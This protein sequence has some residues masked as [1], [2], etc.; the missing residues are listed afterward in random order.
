MDRTSLP[1]TIGRYS[2]GRRIGEG[3]FGDVYLGT[4]TEL[5]RRVA[6][7]SVRIEP[8]APDSLL[9]RFRREA[10][11]LAGIDHPFICKVYELIALD[12]DLLLVMEYI[13]GETLASMLRE[14]PLPIDQALRI[15]AEL[16]EALGCAHDAGIIHRDITPANVIV[17]HNGHVKLVDFGLAKK[18]R[19]VSAE[20]TTELTDQATLMGTLQ[21]M[22]PEQ[23]TGAPVGA[24]ADVFSFGVVL[25]QCLSGRLPY[26]GRDRADYFA[27]LLSDRR[28]SLPD[29]VPEAVQRLVDGC[30]RADPSGRIESFHE[31]RRWLGAERRALGRNRSARDDRDVRWYRSVAML[32]AAAVVVSVG[33]ATWF[34]TRPNPPPSQP[35][36]SQTALI[37]SPF[38]DRDPRLSPDGSTVAFVSDRDGADRLWLGSVDGGAARPVSDPSLSL[39]TPV[40]A[41]G[42]QQVAYLANDGERVGVFRVTLWGEPVG[43]PVWLPDPDHNTSTLFSSARLIRWL[44]DGFI[45][46]L[47][48]RSIWR[49]DPDNGGLSGA[50]AEL[51]GHD[52][53]SAD[54]DPGGAY[55]V[56]SSYDGPQ[57]D[58]WYADI[59]HGDVARL[60]DSPWSESA[61]VFAGD[62]STVLFLSNE[63]GQ[64]DV[65][66]MDVRSRSRRP[67]TT[68]PQR[69]VNAH[70]SADATAFVSGVLNDRA[71]LW[72]AHPDD[73]RT[74]PMTGDFLN[75]YWV[76]GSPGSET[77][78]FHR[79]RPS[80]RGTNMYVDA[81]LLV[82]DASALAKQEPARAVLG[83]FRGRLSPNGDWLAFLRVDPEV[84]PRPGVWLANLPRRTEHHIAE[85]FALPRWSPF[86]LH[87]VRS[88]MAWSPV[89]PR[90]YYIVAAE[91]GRLA[92]R[93]I[94]VDADAGP[95]PGPE[96]FDNPEGLSVQ[97]LMPSPGGELLAFVAVRSD[98]RQRHA[99]DPGSGE[100]CNVTRRYA[101]SRS[102]TGCT[103]V[104]WDGRRRRGRCAQPQLRRRHVPVHCDRVTTATST[105]WPKCR[106]TPACTDS[107]IDVARGRCLPVDQRSTTSPT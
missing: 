8:G 89:E 61:P 12:E 36:G 5:N 39:G 44:D 4:D 90:L 60:S 49:L 21:Y 103:C 50:F 86:P 68:S 26:A 57:Q 56:F 97:D 16:A 47:M 43:S 79:A 31:I 65:W 96:V 42:G 10:A 95:V 75:D 51:D 67:L 34:A 77:V 105:C 33:V 102:S 69:E 63:G 7:K 73:G 18:E 76:T 99:P 13:E 54:I 70:A 46:V 72:V 59:V 11:V 92:I 22:S 100:R 88:N 94:D 37:T 40:W 9:A 80:L 81:Q 28:D 78:V 32:A 98:Q 14:G 29:A 24:P 58:L 107:V 71:D 38:D 48:S 19:P 3:G 30:L 84:G 53:L 2:V 85:G 23:A 87:W 64:V 82:G 62:E 1:P 55:V 15:C 66:L 83:G 25:Y 17:T 52:L 104:G 41:P 74:E 6:I 93:S 91:T 20:T 45:Y 101:D 27:N 35:G 106:L